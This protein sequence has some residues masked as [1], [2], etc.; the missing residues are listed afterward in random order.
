MKSSFF[1]YI[2]LSLTTF[3]VSG[4]EDNI[5]NRWNQLEERIDYEQSRKPKGPNNGYYIEPPYF[6]EGGTLGEV[7]TIE[8]VSYDDIQYSREQQF[9]AGTGNNGVRERIRKGEG[10][11]VEDIDR[12]D[13]APP[14]IN[15][16]N[17]DA[18]DYDPGSFDTSFWKTFLIIFTIVL[19]AILIYFIFVKNKDSDTV[20]KKELNDFEDW[21][22]TEVEIDELTQ[23]LSEA[24]SKNDYR[25][26]VRIYYTLILKELIDKQW[27][28]W[29]KKKTN[30]HYLIEVGGRKERGELEKSVRIFELVWY[31][32]YNIEKKEYSEVEP[33]MN[34]FYQHLKNG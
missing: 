2:V 29:E 22:P 13:I 9:P 19:L 12:P 17:W 1:L 4:Q 6:N 20:V 34:R 30:L 24:L 21:D 8:D 14:D 5:D 7:E 3:F 18:P 10:V 31:G 26:C 15:T 28:K 27:I 23:K 32:D 11:T 33:Q 25:G 16:P